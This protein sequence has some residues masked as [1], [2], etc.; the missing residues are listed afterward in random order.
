MFQNK[1]INTEIS[2]NSNSIKFISLINHCDFVFQKDIKLNF[3]LIKY[4]YF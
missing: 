3:I 2:D 4:D 1:A